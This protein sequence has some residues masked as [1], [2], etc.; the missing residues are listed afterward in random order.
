MVHST[1]R[2]ADAARDLAGFLHGMPRTVA[3]ALA[4]ELEILAG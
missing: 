1:R 4:S 2:A 3:E